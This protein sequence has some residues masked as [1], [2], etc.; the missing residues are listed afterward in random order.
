LVRNKHTG[1]LALIVALA[2]IATGVSAS[3]ATRPATSSEREEYVVVYAEGASLEQARAAITAAGGT[4]IHENTA[5]GVATVTTANASFATAVTQQSAL[6]GASRNRPVSKIAPMLLKRDGEDEGIMRNGERR[7]TSEGGRR[8]GGQLADEPLAGLQWDMQMIHA[9]SSG[10]YRKQRGDRRV[11]VA[12]ID[13]GIDASHPDIAPNFNAALSRNFATDMEDIDGPCEYVGC[14]D[15][16]D[17]DNSGHGTHVAGTIGAALNGLGIAG[18]APN[19]TLVNARAGQDSGYVFLQPVVDALVYSGDIGADVANM[20][21]YIDPWLYNCTN[22]PADSPE[23]QAEQ[24]AVIIATQRAV[25]YARAH[26]V[27]LLVAAGNGH[28]DLGNPTT[29]LTSPDYPVG[30][31]YPRTV[32]NSCLSMP[33]EA[34]GVIPVSAVGPSKAKADYSNYG[35]EQ[36]RIAAPGGYFRDFFGTPQHRVNENQILSTYPK[37]VLEA[38]GLIDADGVPLTTA[39]IRDCQNGV[40]AYYAYLQGTSMASPHAAGVAALIVSEHGIRDHRNRSGLRLSP[41]L[42]QRILERTATETACPEPRLVDYTIVGRTPDFNAYCSGTKS[43]N[44][45]YGHGIVD[46]LNAVR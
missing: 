10:S 2:T 17:V 36:V 40:C 35:T 33:V 23:A 26:G 38:G 29:D 31:E 14:A 32:D 16:S 6:V 15:P 43:F 8:R 22:N 12:V 30:S 39:V 7:S 41:I 34:H 5:V 37:N 25:N 21:F 19:V 1:L 20:S 24:R 46:A 13:S 42:T 28:T 11:I 44:G 27:T 3:P 45:F 9:T 18:V 4:I